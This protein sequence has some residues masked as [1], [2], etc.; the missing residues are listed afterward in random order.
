M[1]TLPRLLLLGLLL[2]ILPLMAS[3]F[4]APVAKTT[5]LP[6]KAAAGRVH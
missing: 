1:K 5:K 2:V 6:V 4:H 3:I